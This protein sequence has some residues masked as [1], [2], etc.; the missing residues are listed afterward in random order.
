MHAICCCVARMNWVG[1]AFLFPLTW[2]SLRH[3]RIYLARLEQIERLCN[4]STLLKGEAWTPLSI[5]RSRRTPKFTLFGGL[6]SNDVVQT[7]IRTPITLVFEWNS[8][9]VFVLLPAFSCRHLL[10][11]KYWLESNEREGVLPRKV[12]ALFRSAAGN[13]ISYTSL[14]PVC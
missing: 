3:G 2:E 8:G 4:I 14:G 12:K 9:M 11:W 6:F 10:E 5:A 13:K 7:W 1:K